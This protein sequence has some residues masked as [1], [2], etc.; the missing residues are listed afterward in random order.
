MCDIK[1]SNA[2]KSIDKLQMVNKYDF[3]MRDA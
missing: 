3:G 2:E 1:K